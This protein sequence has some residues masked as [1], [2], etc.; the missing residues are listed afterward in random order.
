MSRAR[1]LSPL[2]EDPAGWGLGLPPLCVAPLSPHPDTALWAPRSPRPP[3]TRRP[4]SRADQPGAGAA[5]LLTAG[6]SPPSQPW[7]PSL[8]AVGM[9]VL[10]SRGS[11]GSN[12]A[13]P[14]GSQPASVRLRQS[15]LL[16]GAPPGW[17]LSRRL[18]S[19][20]RDGAPPAQP[21]SAVSR[22]LTEGWFCHGSSWEGQ[23]RQGDPTGLPVLNR[24]LCLLRKAQL[25]TGAL[26]G[27][28]QGSL[29]KPRGRGME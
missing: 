6:H 3:G 26:A 5:L 16:A 23:G 29:L 22:C 18:R 4:R 21:S 19:E 7:V 20:H 1:P 15:S 28:P 12:T 25:L 8:S 24:L 14:P 13:W 9:S 11:L 17:G 2:F 10:V 27:P